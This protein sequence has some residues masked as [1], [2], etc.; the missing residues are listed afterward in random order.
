MLFRS[1]H[2]PAS[3]FWADA[4]MDDMATA[5]EITRNLRTNEVRLVLGDFNLNLLRIADNSYTD[6]YAAL[7]AHGYTVAL[8]PPGA[9]PNPVLGY[10][11]YF[12]THMRTVDNAGFWS[13]GTDTAYYPNY[14]YTGTPT[15]PGK[16]DSIDNV[17]YKGNAPNPLNPELTIINGVVG[18]PFRTANPPRPSG[19]T[20]A[21]T[22]VFAPEIDWSWLNPVAPDQ[23]PLTTAIAW[24]GA[25]DWFQGWEAFGKIRST[26]DHL[27][28]YFE[29]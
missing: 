7:T 29:I 8:T 26:S 5:T 16:N 4:F 3:W 22:Q 28:L 21:G 12:A 11:G 19:G 14:I 6:P 18:S 13:S 20:P 2:S 1:V 9:V 27:P 10:R 15:S 25:R 23:G 17:L 24:P